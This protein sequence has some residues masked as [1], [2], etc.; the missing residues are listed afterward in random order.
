MITL[1]LTTKLRKNKTKKRILNKRNRKLDYFM[2]KL[3]NKDLATDVSGFYAEVM[4]TCKLIDI[5]KMAMNGFSS[6]IL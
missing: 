3:M 4:R 1:V 2:V 6:V 5:Q